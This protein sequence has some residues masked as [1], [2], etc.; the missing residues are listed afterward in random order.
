M[1][2]R[3]PGGPDC[4]CKS[5]ALVTGDCLCCGQQDPPEGEQLC[6][7]CDAYLEATCGESQRVSLEDAASQLNVD[8]SKVETGGA[9]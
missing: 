1:T 8:L 4:T 5:C 3:K 9:S 7:R 2:P 6:E